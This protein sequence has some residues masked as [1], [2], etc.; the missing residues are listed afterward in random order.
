MILET[1]GLAHYFDGVAGGDVVP[2]RKP[3]PAHLLAGLKLIG[4]EPEHAVMI[5]D[6]INDVAAAKAAGIPVLVLPSGYGEIGAAELGGDRLLGEF[7]EIPAALQA[8]G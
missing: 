1:L 8:L 3:D 4:G 7:A 2:A 5:G 6:G